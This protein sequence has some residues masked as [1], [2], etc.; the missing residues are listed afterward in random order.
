MQWAAPGAVS[1]LSVPI[2]AR[3]VPPDRSSGTAPPRPAPMVATGRLAAIVTAYG[4]FGF[5]YVITATF[6]VAIVRGA[7]GFGYLEPV[8]WVL[9][10]LAPCRPCR[11]WN[12]LGRRIG[13]FA[14][15]AA[16]CLVEA[17]A[18]QRACSR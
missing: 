8:V 10:G 2:V 1:L 5:G 13:I 6:L 16:A 7:A 14:A 11:L 4:L 9:V 15:F 18:W 12:V 3:L 17:S